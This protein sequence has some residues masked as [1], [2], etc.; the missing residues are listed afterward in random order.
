MFAPRRSTRPTA[1]SACPPTAS[2]SRPSAGRPLNVP[3]HRFMS[4][5][6]TAAGRPRSASARRCACSRRCRT[7]SRPDATT[8][9]TPISNDRPAGV[10]R[11]SGAWRAQ[12]DLGARLSCAIGFGD[13]G[14]ERHAGSAGAHRPRR[15]R[16]IRCATW[17]APTST[18]TLRPRAL[19]QAYNLMNH[20][21]ALNFS[22]VADVA[23]LRSADVGRAAA[24]NRARHAPEFLNRIP[25]PQ[26][27]IPSKL[28]QRD[29][30]GDGEVQ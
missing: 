21:N 20:V 17:A 13:A 28:V 24:P 7:T 5:V 11:N 29:A 23:V 6:N 4:L 22:G 15:Q 19:R 25:N 8:T 3:W 2:T 27:R 16:A 12:V 26:S 18:K 10:T 14:G 30:S 1:R 9:A